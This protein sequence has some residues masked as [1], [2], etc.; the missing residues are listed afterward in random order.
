M[1]ESY[2]I[3]S[4]WDLEPLVDW[5]VSDPRLQCVRY[6]ILVSDWTS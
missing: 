2:V 3:F 5:A 1:T 4:V 6:L